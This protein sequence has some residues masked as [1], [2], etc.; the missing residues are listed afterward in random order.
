MLV[1]FSLR[2]ITWSIAYSWTTKWTLFDPSQAKTRCWTSLFVK[3]VNFL[4]FFSRQSFSMDILV[5]FILFPRCKWNSYIGHDEKKLFCFALK[6][7]FSAL[8]LYSM[9]KQPS[10]LAPQIAALGNQWPQR[11]SHSKGFKRD[12][13][14][15]KINWKFLFWNH[16]NYSL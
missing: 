12:I 16:N 5:Y 1:D 10:P 15:I 8:E 14:G 9:Q 3:I 11:D 7:R 4:C 13:P 6:K 2:D